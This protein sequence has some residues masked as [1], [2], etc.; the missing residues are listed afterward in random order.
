MAKT[1]GHAATLLEYHEGEGSLE[2]WRLLAQHHDPRS[3]EGNHAAMREVRRPTQAKS[4]TG[5][6]GIMIAWENKYQRLN[7][8]LGPEAVFPE[9]ELRQIYL[10]MCP[11]EL[12]K[13]LAEIN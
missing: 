1:H 4:L 3:E 9:W 12:R 2:L 6:H 5:L 10:D 7:T 11:E 8:L 13:E